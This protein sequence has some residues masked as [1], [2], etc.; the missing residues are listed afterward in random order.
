MQ[1]QQSYTDRL[2]SLLGKGA[3]KGRGRA[4]KGA[5]RASQQNQLGEPSDDEK[6]HRLALGTFCLA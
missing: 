1:P 3:E 4:G 6:I 2:E 5:L